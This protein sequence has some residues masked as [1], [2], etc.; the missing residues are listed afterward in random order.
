[1]IVVRI[2][3]VRE[4]MS[5]GLIVPQLH[6]RLHRLL[7]SAFEYTLFSFGLRVDVQPIEN[8]MRFGILGIGYI[9]LRV[10]IL[11]IGY[12]RCIVLTIFV[13]RIIQCIE[14]SARIERLD[15]FT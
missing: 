11:M 9:E 4:R 14:F 8:I 13:L 7:L 1:M 10:V 12:K 5:R 15:L 3:N 6:L 2:I